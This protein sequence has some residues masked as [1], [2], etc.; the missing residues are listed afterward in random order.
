MASIF[1]RPVMRPQI[2]GLG[3]GLSL[4]TLHLGHQRPIKL[5]SGPISSTGVY[6]QV[7]QTPPLRKGKLKPEAIRKISSGSILGTSAPM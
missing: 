2:L 7:P 3:I 6:N 5:D 4:A 1:L